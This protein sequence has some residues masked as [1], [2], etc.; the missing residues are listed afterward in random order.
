MAL[1]KP[2]VATNIIGNKDVVI[3]GETGFLYDDIE[4]LTNY[5]E[6]LENKQTRIRLGK[7]ALKQCHHL[8]DSNKNF[9][10]LMTLYQ[11]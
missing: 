1:Q 5:F 9:N 3:S 11:S 8:F 2:V 7:N 4:A 10:Q 6:I